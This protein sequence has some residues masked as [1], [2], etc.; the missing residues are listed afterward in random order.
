MKTRQWPI[1]IWILWTVPVWIAVWQIVSMLLGSDILLVSPLKVVQCLRGLVQTTAFWKTIGFTFVRIACGFL[2][3]TILGTLLG[4]LS[5]KCTIVR[6]LLQLPVSVIKT[7]PVASIIILLLIFTPSRNLSVIIS[8]LMSFPIVYLNVLKGLDEV[9]DK[10]F[11]LS[12]L[13]KIRYIYI[14]EVLPFFEAGVKLALGL[15]WKSGIAAEIIGI[16]RGS[17]GERL[18]QAK[19]YL[20]TPELFAWTVVIIL[21]SIAFEK[22]VMFLIGRAINRLE[23]R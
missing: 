17:I 23:G 7:T 11:S 6:E 8:F 10:V 12:R 13:K 14:P 16:P 19:I 20:E 15:C 21:I 1:P 3:A 22:L 9:D 18:Y 4:A 2:S 5:K